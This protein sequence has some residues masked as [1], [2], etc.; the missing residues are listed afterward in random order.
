MSEPQTFHGSCHCGAVAYTATVDLS[1]PVVA[2]NC[3]MCSRAGWLLSF[4]PAAQFTLE[5]GADSLTD[6]QFNKRHLHHTFC[7]VCGVRSFSRGTSPDGREMI[8]V[9]VRCLDGVDPATL[10]VRA[11]DGRSL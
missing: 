10:E 1:K 5:R 9:N 6:Y 4:V 8:A 11:F 2:C 7:K 3:S